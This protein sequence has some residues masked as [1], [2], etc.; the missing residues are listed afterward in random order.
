VPLEH[1][2]RGGLDRRAVGDVA[3]L[4]LVRLGLAARQPDRVP[5]ARAERADQ[6]GADA[7][8][9]AGDDR[10]LQI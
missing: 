6:L 8:R 4:V 7:G 5:A 9:R 10:Y 1:A 2:L 3:C